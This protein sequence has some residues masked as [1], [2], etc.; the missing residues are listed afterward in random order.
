M[1]QIVDWDEYVGQFVAVDSV[2][3]RPRVTGYLTQVG[4]KDGQVVR[5][6]QLLFVIDPRPYQAALDQAKAQAQRAAATL[7][8]AKSQAV[9]GQTLLNAKAISQQDYDTLVAAEKQAEADLAAAQATVRS[10]AL[11]LEFTH[12]TAPLGGRISDR[13]VAPGNLVTADQTVLTNIVNLDPIRF[14]FEGSEGNYLKYQRENAEGTR[15]SSRA[16]ANPVEIKLQDEQTYRWKGHMEFVDNTLDTSSGTIRGRAV[17][18]NP[19]SFITPGMFGHMRL[20][21]SGAYRGMLVPT[22]RRW[23]PTRAGRS[24]MWSTPRGLSV[25]R[26]WTTGP[27]IDGLRGRALRPRRE[28]QGGD[29]RHPA[30]QGR[31]AGHP[32]GRQ[33]RNPEGRLAQRLWLSVHAWQFRLHGRS[34]QVG[35]A[36]PHEAFP[37]LHRAAGV[38]RGAGDPDHPGGS[39][40]LSDPAGGAVSANRPADGEHQAPPIPAPRPEVLADTVATPIEEQINGVGRHALPVVQRHRR[41]PP[42]HHRHL[43]ARHRPEHR[44]GAGREPASKP[45]RRSFR[46]RCA[47]SA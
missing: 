19:N 15:T 12:V 10:N 14:Q 5:K 36:R 33:N 9:R 26:C 31:Q 25:R 23:S 24:P 32:A 22:T 44:P 43:Q 39:L 6:G 21:G 34:G 11:N 41:R 13:R 1:R 28:R 4:F 30:R 29:Q 2:D 46:K 17:V 8:N 20:L 18:A 37:L 40:R 3:V 16:M 38:R 27:L 45:R 42:D 35:F 7:A 47:T